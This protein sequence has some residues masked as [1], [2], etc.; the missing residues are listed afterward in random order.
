M[1]Q[2]FYMTIIDLVED[3][4]QSVWN[5]WIK[6]DTWK[7]IGKFTVLEEDIDNRKPCKYRK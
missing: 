4:T 3:S 1:E 5:F 7:N 6:F 2:E